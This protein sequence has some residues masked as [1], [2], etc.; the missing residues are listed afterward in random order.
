MKT[1]TTAKKTYG[2]SNAFS[3]IMLFSVIIGKIIA[4]LMRS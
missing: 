3:T 1:N 2:F 4:T